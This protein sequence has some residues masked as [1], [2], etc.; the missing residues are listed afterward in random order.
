NACKTAWRQIKTYWCCC[1]LAI[2]VKRWQIGKEMNRLFADFSYVSVFLN[3]LTYVDKGKGEVRWKQRLKHIRILHQLNIG[4]NG[5]IPLFY[6]PIIVYQLRLM[7][8]IQ[9]QK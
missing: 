5:M 1:S 9:R 8:Y 4:V 6:R 2:Y 7:A 3:N